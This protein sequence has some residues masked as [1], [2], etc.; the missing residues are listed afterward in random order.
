[1]S[2]GR[3]QILDAGPSCPELAL[4]DGDGDGS[5]RA[6]VWPGMGAK[7]RSLHRITLG[8]GA[9]TV[10]QLHPMEAVYYVIGG[11]ADAVDP[12]DGSRQELVPG[13]FVHIDPATRYAF[14]AGP[15]GAELVGGPCP[16]DPALYVGMA[17]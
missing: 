14:E 13:S 4:V 1:V 11:S 9:R 16:P 15:A 2:D 10:E 3:V 12:S 7:H 17:G 5:A 6:V 8:A